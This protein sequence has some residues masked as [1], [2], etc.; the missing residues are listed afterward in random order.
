MGRCSMGLP[1]RNKGFIIIL[2]KLWEEFKS[3]LEIGIKKCASKDHK[4]TRRPAVGG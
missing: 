4:K 2:D 3:A 1:S